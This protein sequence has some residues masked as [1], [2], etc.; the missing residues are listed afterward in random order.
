MAIFGGAIG[1]KNAGGIYSSR[2]AKYGDTS[3]LDQHLNRA[4][5]SFV[6]WDAHSRHAKNN[7]F[8]PPS[9]PMLPLPPLSMYS[10]DRDTHRYC[11]TFDLR[12]LLL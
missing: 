2:F 3:Y 7:A 11:Y 10:P 1:S 12:S 6:Q 9:L 4:S 5:G 8:S